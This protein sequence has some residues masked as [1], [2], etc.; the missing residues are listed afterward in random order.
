M[1]PFIK[2]GKVLVTDRGDIRISLLETIRN[3]LGKSSTALSTL[4]WGSAMS[5]QA[6]RLLASRTSLS[7][8]F[9]PWAK[10]RRAWY[11]RSDPS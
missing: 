6:R 3:K 5:S 8:W 7:K 2:L 11:H 1:P 9:F 10:C 4:R